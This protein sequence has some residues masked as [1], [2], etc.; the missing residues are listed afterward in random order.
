[1]TDICD[2]I[3]W[4]PHSVDQLVTELGTGK[5]YEIL[6]LLK[7]LNGQGLIQFEEL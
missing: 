7:D 3:K 6:V 5:R 4:Q 2:L 1:M